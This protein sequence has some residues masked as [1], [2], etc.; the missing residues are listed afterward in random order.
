MRHTFTMLMIIG[1]L[2][3]APAAFAAAPQSAGSTKTAATHSGSHALRGVVKS[4][5]DSTLVVTPSGK[6][7]DMTFALNQATTKEGSPA[8]GSMVAVR[9]KTEAGKNVAT[10]VAVQSAKTGKS[11][12]GK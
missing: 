5:D 1:A 4:M 3:L 10:A 9:Y 8:V 7:T 11:K 12:N 2:A 6:K